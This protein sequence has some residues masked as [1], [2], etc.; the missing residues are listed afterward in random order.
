VEVRE[1]EVRAMARVVSHWPVTTEARVH[2]RVNTCGICGG[3]SGTGMGFSPNS[4][5][6]PCQYIIPPLLSKLISYGECII[7]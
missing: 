5:V 3:Q 2:A 6:F 4:S 7:C 1:L